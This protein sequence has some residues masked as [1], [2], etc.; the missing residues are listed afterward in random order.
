MFFDCHSRQLLNCLFSG[1]RNVN[2]FHYHRGKSKHLLLSRLFQ[3]MNLREDR[4]VGVGRSNEL[5]C[6]S[7]QLMIQAGL[8]HPANPGCFYYL[9]YTVRALEKLIRVIDE[10]MES[11]GSQKVNMPSLSTAELWKISERWQVMGKELFRLKDRHGMDYCLSPTHEE[12]VTHLIASYGSLSYKQLPVMLY[13]ITRKFRDEPKPR[14]GLL[15]GREFYMKDMYTFDVSEEA[16]KETYNIVCES[17]SRI[18]DRLGLR[19]VKVEADTGSIGGKMS[20][21]FQIP[22]NIG[23]D[24]ILVCL[25]C[26][27]AANVEKMES[28]GT[29][30][31]QCKG[32]LTETKGIEVG[33]TFYLGTKY[34]HV[35]K[36]SYHN[37][38]NKP[39]TA[40]MGCFGLGVTRILAASVEILSTEDD[41]RWP[42]LLAPYQVCIVPPKRGSKEDVTEGLSESLYDTLV[43][44]AP[45]LRGEVILD[46]RSHL[47]VGKRLKDAKRLGYPYVII[48]GKRI[49]EDPP[50]FEVCCQNVGDTLFLTQEGVVDILRDVQTV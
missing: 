42:S 30:C 1:Y 34:S 24:R 45:Q 22:A 31:P 25:A 7:Q 38:E 48:A 8:I 23:E 32:K 2:R 26:R 20:H 28:G 35:F 49:L 17:Y 11:I 43:D 14:F 27:F 46:D 9:P 10:E 5:T 50:V 19:F 36:A 41:I 18:F 29:D 33:H 15:R 39:V 4:V 21:E 47:T 16:A 40:E 44:A 3:P 12:A 13:Q 37:A 6:K